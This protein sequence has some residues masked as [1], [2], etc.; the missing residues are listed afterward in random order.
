MEVVLT[1]VKCPGKINEGNILKIATERPFAR[2][3]GETI[4]AL[5][6]RARDQLR[7][8]VTWANY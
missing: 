1:F 5:Y 4:L 3:I 8:F 7:I 6:R 2:Y